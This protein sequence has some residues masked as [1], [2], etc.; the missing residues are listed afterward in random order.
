MNFPGYFFD[1]ESEKALIAPRNRHILTGQLACAC[2]EM[3]LRREELE[4]FVGGKIRGQVPK[5]DIDALV[6]RT[7]QELQPL[8]GNG[9]AE[10][11]TEPFSRADALGVRTRKRLRPC[12]PP[13]T[14][15]LEDESASP[16]AEAEAILAVMEEEG[17]VREV[18]GTWY[19]AGSSKPAYRVS[20]RSIARDSFQIVD[21]TDPTHEV[22]I[23]DIDQFSAYPILHPEAIYL[24]EGETYAVENLDLERKRAEVRRVEASYYTSPLGGRGVAIIHSVDERVRFPGGEAWFG[25]VTCHF[26]TVAYDKIRLWSREPF[27]R[28]PVRL[29]PQILETTAYWLSPADDT[30]ARIVAS[31]RRPYDGVYGLGQALMVTTALFAS[32]YPLDV[33]YSEPPVNECLR[34][35]CS[36]HSTFIFDNYQGSLGFAELAFSRIDELLETT[37]SLIEECPCDDGCPFCVGFYLRPFIRHDP[38][39]TEGWIADKE[40]ALMV[41]HDLLGLPAYEPKPEGERRRS[42]RARVESEPGVEPGGV[43]EETPAKAE[44]LP[45]HIRG[46]I[47]RRLGKGGKL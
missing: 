10:N 12:S 2:Y 20:L 15:L 43:P 44:G 29:P 45:E 28:R 22:I 25:D 18:N 11:G 36:P 40:V 41:L 38:E 42:W 17:L 6:R 4:T 47:L 30:V 8:A 24:H 27:D 1:K 39:N 35:G 7:H 46:Q 21:V 31:G 37:L 32:C 9:T 33:R 16:V 14:P 3:P 23:G 13:P 19:Y 26:N 34:W 5:R